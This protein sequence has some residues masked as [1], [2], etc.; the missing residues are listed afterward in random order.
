LSQAVDVVSGVKVSPS[1]VCQ[2]PAPLFWKR[3]DASPSA[4]AVW[5]PHSPS[6]L[7]SQVTCAPPTP[8]SLLGWRTGVKPPLFASKLNGTLSP[9]DGPEALARIPL[10]SWLFGTMSASPVSRT[11]LLLRS[12]PSVLRTSPPSVSHIV[13]KVMS[14][15]GIWM[16]VNGS[17]WSA[18]SICRLR[19]RSRIS[20]PP[21]G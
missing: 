2:M 16:P 15:S 17:I 4:I 12:S 13:E 7:Y 9:A 11:P 1:P 5:K 6:P 14:S 20:R 18:A 10:S 21:F 19:L 8:A 3:G